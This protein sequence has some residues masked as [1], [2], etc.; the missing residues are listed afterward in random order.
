[1][2]AWK[3]GVW[4]GHGRTING[5]P[6][7]GCAGVA[8]ASDSLEHEQQLSGIEVRI[9]A[10]SWSRSDWAGPLTP[11]WHVAVRAQKGSRIRRLA[12]LTVPGEC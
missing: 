4:R 6:S 9:P 1:M 12:P 11:V 2:T 8:L 3:P 10:R 5:K 7:T